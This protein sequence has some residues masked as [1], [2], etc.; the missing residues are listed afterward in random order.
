MTSSSDNYLGE[1]AME[2]ENDKRVRGDTKSTCRMEEESISSPEQFAAFIWQEKAKTVLCINLS[3]NDIYTTEDKLKLYLISYTKKIKINNDWTAPLGIFVVLV[4]TLLTT[5]FNEVF[6]SSH[7]WE[8]I[9]VLGGLASF[10]WLIISL[11]NRFKKE[12]KTSIDKI[13]TEIRE[14]KEP[15]VYN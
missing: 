13:I 2:K 11:I 5:D 1:R 14:G 6:L 4:T 8:A 3:K 9:F 7:T 10:V 15:S 12:N